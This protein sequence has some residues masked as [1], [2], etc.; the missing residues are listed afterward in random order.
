LASSKFSGSADFVVTASGDLRV[1]QSHAYLS[2]GGDVL[3]AGRATFKD[4]SLMRLDN[5]SGHYKPFGVD[6]AI[7]EGAFNASGFN[8]NGLY[9]ETLRPK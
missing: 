9:R 1:G 2:G 8:A 4:G 7:P 5:W 6:P 3:S